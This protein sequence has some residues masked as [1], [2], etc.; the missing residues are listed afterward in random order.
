MSEGSSRDYRQAL[1]DIDMT[2]PNVAR[3]YELR[4]R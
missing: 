1:A 2:K 3:V 4:R